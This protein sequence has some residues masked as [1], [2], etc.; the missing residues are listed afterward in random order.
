MAPYETSR[1]DWQ[2][3]A[4]QRVGMGMISFNMRV[5]VSEPGLPVASLFVPQASR[6]V[7]QGWFMISCVWPQ[8]N[9]SVVRYIIILVDPMCVWDEDRDGKA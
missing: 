1:M 6:P 4:R 2:V 5:S 3:Q 7:L 8:V 9:S